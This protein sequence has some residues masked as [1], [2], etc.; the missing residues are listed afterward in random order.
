MMSL[1]LFLSEAKNTENKIINEVE[2]WLHAGTD[3][4]GIR[5]KSYSRGWH[6]RL[7]G[8]DFEFSEN[9]ASEAKK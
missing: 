1:F 8:S 3:H 2:M 5:G 9:K 7:M 6:S 4:F